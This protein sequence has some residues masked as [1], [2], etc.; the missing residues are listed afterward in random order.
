MIKRIIAIVLTV[1][2]ILALVGCGKQKRPI[3]RLTLSTEDSEAIL[4]AAGVKLPS[5][6][7]TSAAGTTI[8]YYGCDDPIHNYSEDE[9]IHTGYWTFRE[10]YNCEVTWIECTWG[11][12]FTQ[13]ANLVLAGTSPDF[14]DTHPETFP[15]YY[16]NNRIFDP[17][18]DYIDYDDPLW[19]GIKDFAQKY[20]SIG[21]HYYVFVTDATYNNVCAYNRRVID[22]YGYDDPAELFYNNEWTWAKFYD[23]CLGFSDP[24]YDRYAL[25]GW[26]INP[27]F[28]ASSGTMVVTLDPESGKF[29]SNLDDPRLERAAGYLYNL[30]KNECVYPIWKKGSPRGV[31]GAGIKEGLCLFWLR[32]SW[33]FTGPVSEMAPIWGDIENGELMFCPLPR[34]ELGDGNYYVDT[35]PTGFSLIKGAKNPE[36]VALYAACCRFKVIDPT[37]IDIDRRQLKEV[38]LWTDEMLDMRDTMYKLAGSYNTV[39]D[40]EAGIG[41]LV[42]YVNEC[43][44]ITTKRNPSTWAQSKEANNDR[45]NYYLDVLNTQIQEAIDADN[46]A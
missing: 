36:G 14:Y 23:M 17:V 27:S 40:Y 6:E 8:E 42:N 41:D 26:G 29:V 19:S 5:A 30:S 31:D 37:V 22:E 10:K 32:M 45:I 1:V 2:L 11:D 16:I 7:E 38:Y 28:F 25:D 15:K 46:N 13:L 9:I 39:I 3:I 20:F 44:F 33:A 35:V 34:D 18:D 43:I 4:A 21:D 12:R 24:D